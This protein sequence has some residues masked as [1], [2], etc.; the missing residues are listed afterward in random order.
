MQTDN[1]ILNEDPIQKKDIALMLLLAL[2]FSALSQFSLGE[3]K[4]LFPKEEKERTE[5]LEKEEVR[6]NLFAATANNKSSG[7]DS[8]ND[9]DN[10]IS[11]NDYKVDLTFLYVFV[12][13]LF[14]QKT[15]FNLIRRKVYLL[16]HKLIFYDS[17]S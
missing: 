15:Y 14:L 9:F 6:N 13:N 5:K 4:N 8:G 16:L 7:G 3:H 11:H 1:Y 10:D 2:C 17:F 12:P